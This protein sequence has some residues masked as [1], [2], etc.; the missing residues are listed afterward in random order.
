MNISDKFH[1]EDIYKLK[2][3]VITGKTEDLKWR[4]KQINKK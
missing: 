1:L 4:I 3:K 2:N